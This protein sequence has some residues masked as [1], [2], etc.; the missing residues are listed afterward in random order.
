M[1]KEVIFQSVFGVDWAAL[2]PVMKLHYANRAHSHDCVRAQG[3][4]TIEMS[5][6]MR[7]LRPLLR[8]TR[9]LVPYAGE[10]IPTTVDFKSNP[11]DAS[12]TLDRTF[13]LPQG[14]YRFRSSMWALKGGEVIEVMPSRLVWRAHYSWGQGKVQMQHRGYALR[15]LGW[16]IPLPLEFLFG[17]G[18]A[19]EEATGDSSFRM[20]MTMTHALLGQI[21]S[22]HGTFEIKGVDLHD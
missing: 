7:L 13:N 8:L 19:E 6:L 12:F 1:E 10:N 5:K 11:L 18:Y 2:P 20:R 4:M 21:Y 15:L 3:L 17:K 9:T 14:A 16:K 22:Y